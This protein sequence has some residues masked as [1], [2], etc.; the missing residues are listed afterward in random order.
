MSAVLRD[1]PNPNPSVETVGILR[2]ADSPACHGGDRK[3]LL[4]VKGKASLSPISRWRSDR[5]APRLVAAAANMRGHVILRHD[6]R[7]SE[8]MRDDE[9]R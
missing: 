8:T 6:A 7:L 3:V 1:R 9:A 4:E 5:C 2:F